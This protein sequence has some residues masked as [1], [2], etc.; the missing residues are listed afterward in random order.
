MSRYVDDSCLQLQTIVD[1]VRWGA[2]CFNE[3]GLF[4]GHGTDN[5][6]DESL[7]LVLHALHLKPGL[8]AEL[9]KSRLLESEKKQV[10]EMIRRRIEERLPSPYLTHEAWFGGLSFY[11]DERV[12][13][14]RS[15]IA[16]LIEGQFSPWVESEG[17]HSLLDL[18]TGSGCIAIASAMAFPRAKVDAVD[19]S[20]DALEVAAINVERH[21]MGEHVTPIESDL[22]SAL[23]GKRYDLIVS[24]PPYVDAEDLAEMPEEF[25]QEPELGLASGADGLDLT[26]QILSQAPDYL[27][28]NGTLVVEVG[29]SEAALVERFPDVPFIWLDFERGGEGVFLLHAETL[30]EY[31]DQFLAA[32]G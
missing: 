25:H 7:F 3:A 26:V 10:V 19:I 9:M 28:E 8:P 16:E 5:A 32:L 20:P 2:S 22:F 18:C 27:T 14:P 12:L 17:V 15:P 31:R 11:V 24:N 29:N 1:F 30:L 21:N 23:D 4:F 6:V 13:V